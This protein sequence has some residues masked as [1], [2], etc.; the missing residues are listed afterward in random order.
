MAFV[1]RGWIPPGVVVHISIIPRTD[2]IQRGFFSYLRVKIAGGGIPFGKDHSQVLWPLKESALKTTSRQRG[3]MP[4]G[5]RA[6]CKMH[7][8]LCQEN[9]R[10]TSQSVSSLSKKIKIKLVSAIMAATFGVGLLSRTTFSGNG[11]AE[12][13]FKK[14]KLDP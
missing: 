13:E 9:V 8:L 11:T 3:R 10:K 5:N 12:E 7:N 1:Q 6:L 2:S 14:I 4:G